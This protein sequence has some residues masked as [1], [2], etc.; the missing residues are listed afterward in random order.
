[1]EYI[2]ITTWDRREYFNMYLGT[3]FPYINVG[4]HIDIT[5]LLRFSKERS[6]SSFLTMIFA[7]HRVAEGIINFKYRI[8]DGKPVVIDRICPCFTHLPNGS[9]LFI[10][11]TVE[12]ARDVIEFHD[13]ARKQIAK[14]GND[15]GIEIFRGRLDIIMYSAIPWIEY[16]HFV[17]TISKGGADSNPKISWGKY[18]NQGDQT[19]VPFSV[20][21]HHGLMDGLHV[22][23]YFEGLQLY[24]DQ[25]ESGT[26][27]S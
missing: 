24:I 6:L 16:T 20:Q 26:R 4:A 10:N 14:Q 22:G 12:P 9:D 13:K 25:L 3:D 21:V 8:K 15:L 23:R 1:M 7:A 27:T 5:N 11:V 18:I 17:R 19:F 2:D